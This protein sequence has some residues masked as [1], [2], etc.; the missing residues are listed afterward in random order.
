MARRSAS[1]QF[2]RVGGA[3]V[4]ESSYL[5]L[6]CEVGAG[7]VIRHNSVV[8]RGSRVGRDCVIGM[9]VQIGP[10]AIVGDRCRIQNHV[11]LYR[12]VELEDDVFCGP[13]CVF[14][15]VRN[16]RA[17][18]DR[19]RMPAPTLVRRGATIGANATIVAGVELGSYCFVAAGAVVTRPVAAFA[20]VAGVPARAVGWVSQSGD[21]LDDDLVCPTTGQCYRLAGDGG[22]EPVSDD[23]KQDCGE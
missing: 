19:S 5:D 12:G 14:T 21:R 8:R 10:D 4:H 3:L 22:L 23:A 20:L 11:S 1:S 13:S 15:N 7:T 17:E 6:P 9:G 2:R 16:P 18:I